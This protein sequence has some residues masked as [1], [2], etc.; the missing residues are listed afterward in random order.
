MLST[1]RLVGQTCGAA[2]V[3]LMFNLFVDDG[4][5]VALLAASAFAVIAALVSSS[6][7]RQA[8]P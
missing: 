3:A 1:A 2:L 8:L 4:T 5:H 7:M 6:R